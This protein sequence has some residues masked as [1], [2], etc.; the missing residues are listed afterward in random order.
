[1]RAKEKG[2]ITVYMAL[3][4][5]IMLSLV[6]TLLEGARIRGA[7][8]D[9][10]RISHMAAE[11]MFAEY[12]R[13]LLEEYDI[14][15][16]DASYGAAGFDISVPAHRAEKFVSQNPDRN[17]GTV[18]LFPRTL[19]GMEITGYSLLT[20]DGGAPFRRQACDYMK[21]S[22]LAESVKELVNRIADGGEEAGRIAEQASK[23]AKDAKEELAN[24]DS[25]VSEEECTVTDEEKAAAD[26]VS[27]EDKGLLE[28]VKE[29]KDK[30]VLALVGVENPS[31]KTIELSDAVSHRDLETG[32]GDKPADGNKTS[33]KV[34]F[35]AYMGEKLSSYTDE[36]DNGALSYELEYCYAGKDSDRE[37]LAAVVQALLLIREG[38][39][40]ARLIT[41]SEKVNEARIIAIAI[42]G[43]LALPGLIA[44]IQYGIL[45]AWA[46]KDSVEDV[47]AL[48]AGEKVALI[49]TAED[50]QIQLGYEDYLQI[51]LF[52]NDTELLTMRTM[53]M[54]EQDI[55]KSDYCGNLCLDHVMTGCSWQA[56]YVGGDVFL[57]VF[58]KLGEFNEVYII[59]DSFYYK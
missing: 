12:Q 26:E 17:I 2:S 48:L 10:D 54:V 5:V 18:N 15:G 27:E 39:N 40:F 3:C 51:L 29:L 4:L 7:R 16:L 49:D 55:R 50:K 8:A 31:E 59:S 35:Q 32:N 22:I 43:V 1:M 14:F 11:S 9:A 41:D 37:N 56:E 30:G 13:E 44:A 45:A 57:N 28:S 36:G 25:Y 23:D 52:V 53:D 6:L 47:R 33:D 58:E 21:G 24:E 20:D 42:A 38:L 19:S 46:F 34:L